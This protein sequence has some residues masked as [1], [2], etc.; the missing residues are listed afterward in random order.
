MGAFKLVEAV[1][2]ELVHQALLKA[3]GLGYSPSQKAIPCTEPVVGSSIR[4]VA[5]PGAI[6][7]GVHDLSTSLPKHHDKHDKHDKHLKTELL[8]LVP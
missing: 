8:V 7:Y 6:C 4:T 5:N 1:A 2:D 3:R